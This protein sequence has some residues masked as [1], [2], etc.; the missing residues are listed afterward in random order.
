M[1]LQRTGLDLGDQPAEYDALVSWWSRMRE[2]APISYDEGLGHWHVFR[3]ADAAAIMADHTTFSSDLR[4]LVAQPEQ[5]AVVA[6]GAFNGFDPPDHRKLRS[7]VSKAFTPRVVEAL[8]PRVRQITQDLLDAVAGSPGFELISE[9]AYPLP[10]MVIAELMEIPLDDRERF[11]RWADALFFQGRGDEP[12]IV[13]TEQMLLSIEPEIGEMNEYFLD[14]IDQRRH[15]PGTDLVS[16]LAVVEVDGERL[17]D[18]EILGVC[19]FL[20]VAG[21]ITTTM[22]LGNAIHLLSTH[23]GTATAL[24]ADPAAIPTA[25]EEVLRYRGQLPATARR[26][27]REVT[28]ADRTIPAGQVL[29]VWVASANLDPRQFPEAHRLRIDRDPNRHLALGKGIHYCLGAPLARMEQRIALEE[30]LRRT[31]DFGIGGQL[32]FVNPLQA[33]GLHRLPLHVTWRH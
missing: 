3:Y 23:P 2:R 33:I 4:S 18:E 27:T 22:V 19:G 24:R 15:R 20:L 26:T 13:P 5:F 32:R 21:H 7:L 9:L 11:R 14:I 6:K 17:A 28:V 10:L 12:V 30:L 29:L 8:E 31:E 25:V 16:K 1:D